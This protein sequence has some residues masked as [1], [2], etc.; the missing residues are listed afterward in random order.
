MC[1]V[2]IWRVC[3]GFNPIPEHPERRRMPVYLLKT[4]FFPCAP[5]NIAPGYVRDSI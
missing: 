1:Y 3:Y 2:L 4:V 5:R